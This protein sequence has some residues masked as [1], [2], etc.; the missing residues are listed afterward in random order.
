MKQKSPQSSHSPAI[1]RVQK[2]LQRPEKYGPVRGRLSGEVLVE[3]PRP[4]SLL[5]D[6]GARIRSVL[7]TEDFLGDDRYDA[8]LKALLGNAV[9]S[10]VIEEAVMKRISDTE[11]AQGII[12]ICR[13]KADEIAGISPEKNELIAVSDGI[14]DPGNVGAIIRNCS[15]AGIGSFV[16]LKGSA[17]P[18]NPKA[19]RASAGCISDV[20]IILAERGEFLEW[21]R[22]EGVAVVISESSAGRTVYEA[23]LEGSAAIVFGSEA[24]GVS[25]EVKKVSA[26]GIKVPIYGSVES[27][28]VASAAAVILYELARKRDQSC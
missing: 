5:I 10:Y 22:K 13:V 14:Q 8:L 20:R 2:I 28:N 7:V 9:P 24:A 26:Y 19:I 4:L 16:S 15:G 12:S 23:G 18:F 21:C 1:K 11:T 27:L 3:G 6:R 25:E 17:S